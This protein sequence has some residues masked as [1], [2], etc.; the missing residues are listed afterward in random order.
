MSSRNLATAL[1]R[2]IMQGIGRI[3]QEAFRDGIEGD[4][5]FGTLETGETVQALDTAPSTT[6]KHELG[7][8]LVTPDGRVFR[9]ARA[10]GTLNTDLGVMNASQQEVGYTTV[11]ASAILG[12]TTVVLDVGAGDGIADDGVI[13]VNFL[14]NGY[15]LVFP[16]SANSFVRRILTNTV[17]AGAG[18]M[19]LTLDDGIPASIT[20]D[21]DHCE[22]MASPYYDVQAL[23]S[24]TTSVLGI[25]AWAMTVGQFGWIQTRGVCWIAPQGDVSTGNNDRQV[26]FRHDGSVDQHDYN[27][28]NTRL[29]QHAGF[30]IKQGNGGGQGAPFIFLQIE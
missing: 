24:T 7:A 16:H 19:T 22:C 13:A 2:N 15:L 26:I 14:K 11:A 8:R 12:A 1:S 10:G 27:D 9:Y 21:V 25:P 30:I 18:E 5:H 4:V 6:Q 23:T 17:T 28:V 3:I 20:V 29:G